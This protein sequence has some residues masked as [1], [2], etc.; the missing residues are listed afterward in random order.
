MAQALVCFDE[1]ADLVVEAPNPG[2]RRE[3]IE[4]DSDVAGTGLDMLTRERLGAFQIRAHDRERI[5]V[6]EDL[7]RIQQ[8]RSLH[9]CRCSA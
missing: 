1:V 3:L 5:V 6:N 8:Y 9:D 4:F 7:E 2:R